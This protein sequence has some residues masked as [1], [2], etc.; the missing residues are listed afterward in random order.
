MIRAVIGRHGEPPGGHRATRSTTN[1]ACGCSTTTDVFQRFTDWLRRRYGTV[2]RLNEEWGL[3]YWSHRLSRWDDLW[4]PE[5]NFQPQYDLA[6]R[7][8]QAEL[9]TEFIGWQADIVRDVTGGRRLR[10][11]LH[12]LRAARRRRREA[13]RTARRRQRQR[14]LRDAGLPRATPADLPRSTGPMGW[15]VRGPWAVA[16]LADLMYS[17]KQAPFLVTETNAGLDRVLLDEPVPVRRAVAP[18]GLAARG[19]RRPDGRVLALAHAPLRRRDPLGRRAAA[20]RRSPAGRTAR[21]PGSARSSARSATPSPT[22]RRTTTSPCSTTPTASSPWRT[23]GPVPGDG[24]GHGR[25]RLLPAHRG[26]LL[27]RDL[28]RQAAAAAGPP[29]AA[30]TTWTLTASPCSS[31]P[32]CTRRRTTTSTASPPTPGP[33]AT[34]CV[35][36][37]TGYGDVEGRAR[38]ERAPARSSAAAGT[39]FEETSSLLEPVPVDGTAGRRGDH[40]GRGPRPRRRRGAG[41][42][43]APAPGPLG[44]RDHPTGRRRADH[45]RRHGPGP[46]AR[47]RPRPLAGS[48]ARRRLDDGCLGDRGQQQ[49]LRR[50]AST[51]STTGAGR[52]PP[53]RPPPTSRTCSTGERLRR[54]RERA[55]RAVGRAGPLQRRP[56]DRPAVGARP[57][58]TRPP[59]GSAGP[60]R[61]ASRGGP[62]RS[63]ALLRRVAAAW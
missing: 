23:Q 15:V 58:G 40:A 31:S 37:R 60:P 28:R 27:P 6:W 26:R 48:V 35:G 39:W 4:Q 38:A 30:A 3:V 9:V 44:G 33:G 52:R 14:L 34:S 25:P 57:T 53:R 2:E 41:H 47:R 50:A 43:R 62:D 10:H 8:F 36:P 16:N 19:A 29:R 49:H 17:S 11:H 63:L 56:A 18:D 24:L 1:R 59:V 61:I 20:Q 21:S 22:R 32:P 13:Q 42:L 5:G 54:G 12:L 45:G 55:A 7:R 51:S 46:G